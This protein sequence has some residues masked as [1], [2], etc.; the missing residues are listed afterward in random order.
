MTPIMHSRGLQASC[1]VRARGAP[2]LLENAIKDHQQQL[3]LLRF[4]WFVNVKEDLAQSR[5]LTRR[6]SDLPALDLA[7]AGR[8]VSPCLALCLQPFTDN[9]ESR[10]HSCS[11]A[12]PSMRSHANS[13]RSRA[14]LDRGA[15][16]PALSRSHAVYFTPTTSSNPPRHAG[17]RRAAGGGP[18]SRWVR[19]RAQEGT[20]EPTPSVYPARC[21]LFSF[22][23]LFSTFCS[24]L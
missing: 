21:S 8:R 1:V 11:I 9:P 7:P 10:H 19:A 5:S 17:R 15:C 12:L 13:D 23:F 24:K 18:Y 22:F 3:L 20:S 16:M 6:R 2:F 4:G 14:R